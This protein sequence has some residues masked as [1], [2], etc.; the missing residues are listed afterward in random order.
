MLPNKETSPTGLSLIETVST[1]YL[2]F[3]MGSQFK[4]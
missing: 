4:A 2:G 1:D 3:G